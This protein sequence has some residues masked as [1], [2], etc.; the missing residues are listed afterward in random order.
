MRYPKLLRWS[1]VPAG[2]GLSGVW[3]GSG[4][5]W[6]E[7]LG[8]SDD[9]CWPVTG[10]VQAGVSVLP[11]NDDERMSVWLRSSDAGPAGGALSLGWST[12]T[13]VARASWCDTS[14]SW[15]SST[16]T[17]NDVISCALTC[18]LPRCSDIL[19]A[20]LLPMLAI[21]LRINCSL[22]LSFLAA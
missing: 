2:S 10:V 22:A 3:L 19:A 9:G 11:R 4:V 17:G 16:E 12:S 6:W 5:K 15:R 20:L 21:P 14:V 13:L 8:Q 18:A 7:W 1:P